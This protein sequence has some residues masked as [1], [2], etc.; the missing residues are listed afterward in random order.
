VNIVIFIRNHPIINLIVTKQVP[1]DQLGG[2]INR[3]YTIPLHATI[4]T[5]IVA[6]FVDPSV[7][8]AVQYPEKI[9]N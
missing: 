1:Q 6:T 7:I 5:G 8:A 4:L 9:F 2:M 3:F